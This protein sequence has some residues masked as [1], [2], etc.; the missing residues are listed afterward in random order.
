MLG[1]SGVGSAISSLLGGSGGLG[2]LSSLSDI[3]GVGDLLGGFG[4][5]GG[6]SGQTKVAAGFTNTVNRNTVDVAV[7]KILGSKLIPT[8]VFEYQSAK[9]TSATNNINQAQ[10][11]LNNL[12]NQAQST[13]NNVINT[14]SN[15]ISSAV[16]DFFG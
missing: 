2:A 5:G 16:S 3:P 10:N 9:A 6:L 14:A 1:G 13:I 15:D 11:V 12:Q 4:G 7:T 8:P